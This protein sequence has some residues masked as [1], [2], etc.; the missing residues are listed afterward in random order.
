MFDLPPQDDGADGSTGGGDQGDGSGG[1]G[2]GEED[3]GGDDGGDDD[4]IR[5]DVDPDDPG[6][7]ESDDCD[8]ETDP[9]CN[10]TAVDIL[11]VIDN[12]GSM[13]DHRPALATAFDTFVDEMIAALPGG[14]DLRVGLTRA[15]GFYL[16]GNSGGWNGSSCEAALID[17]TWNPPTNGDNGVNGQQGRLFEH[18]GR[19]YFSVNTDEDPQPLRDWFGGALT[20]AIDGWDP[21]SNTETV[22]AG[23]AYPFHPAN[24]AYNAGFMRMQSVL[25]LFLLSDSPDLSPTDI[26]TSEFV[27][28][29]S[30]AKAGCGDHCIV[31]TGAIAGGCYDTPGIT[32]TRFFDFMN[33]FGNPPASFVE[34]F[35]PGE[36]FSGVLDTALAEVI[37]VACDQIPPEG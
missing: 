21:H 12:S 23:A 19:R 3:D 6:P 20:G 7:G 36:D 26:P 16:P 34:L 37:A 9:E 30:T 10:C 1:G 15:T 11:F 29:V 24:D 31:T 18:E 14:T 27:S 2:D 33:G 32:N 22:I 25:V 5:Y 17:G 35:G 4:G 28:M 13:N 8:P